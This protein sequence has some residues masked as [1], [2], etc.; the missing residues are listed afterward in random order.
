MLWARV[1]KEA[2]STEE[3]GRKRRQAFLF[4]FV[5][6]FC[7]VE[8]GSRYVAKAILYLLSLG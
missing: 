6:G 7:F 3:E 8:T 4:C 2:C 1:G 5:W